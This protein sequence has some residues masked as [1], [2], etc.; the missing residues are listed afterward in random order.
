MRTMRYKSRGWFN[1]SYRHS[2]AA[3]GVRLAKKKEVKPVFFAD[4]PEGSRERSEAL[5]RLQR[6]EDER[7]KMGGL[8]QRGGMEPE[9][10]E[11]FKQAAELRDE[12]K[13]TDDR[14]R[15]LTMKSRLEGLNAKEKSELTNLIIKRS[16]TGLGSSVSA[17]EAKKIG[18]GEGTPYG[19]ELEEEMEEKIGQLDRKLEEGEF[20][21]DD[22]KHL[23]KSISDQEV[24]IRKNSAD[25]GPSRTA[26]LQSKLSKVKAKAEDIVREGEELESE[27]Y[28]G[29][30]PVE[31]EDGF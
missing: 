5:E 11:K 8:G 12:L 1:E 3:K 6:A 17:T 30:D 21:L 23:N 25:L 24:S 16:D 20:S 4:L 13:S 26:E 14:I 2:L 10:V 15:D 7:R 9:K 18:A 28:F 27:E 29:E 31:T 22:I 19:E